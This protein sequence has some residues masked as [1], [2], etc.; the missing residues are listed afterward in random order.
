MLEFDAIPNKEQETSVL[1]LKSASPNGVYIKLTNPLRDMYPSH[2]GD[3][4]VFRDG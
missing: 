4:G 3:S 2:R 1:P